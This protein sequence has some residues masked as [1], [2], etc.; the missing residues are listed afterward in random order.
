MEIILFEV[1]MWNIVVGLIVKWLGLIEGDLLFCLIVE[2]YLKD[3]SLGDFLVI[4]DYIVVFNWVLFY[5]LGDMVVNVFCVNDF[6]L[7]IF[8]VIDI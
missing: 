2:F 7:G 5:E 8:V 3:D 1:V 6:F 4:E